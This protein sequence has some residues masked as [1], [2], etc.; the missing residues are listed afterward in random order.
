MPQSI[1]GKAVRTAHAIKV[2]CDSDIP[3]GL[4]GEVIWDEGGSEVIVRFQRDVPN[5]GFLLDHKQ[6]WLARTSLEF[7]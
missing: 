1:Q 6:V 4:D 7:V 3:A 5:G 2:G